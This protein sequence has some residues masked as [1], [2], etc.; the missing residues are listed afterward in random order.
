MTK[1][2]TGHPEGCWWECKLVQ[3]IG[4]MVQKLLKR[5]FLYD[6]SN[7]T[8]EYLSKGPEMCV[9]ATKIPKQC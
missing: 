7:F 1:D 5:E 9:F 6:R 3:H 8:S 2:V 4:K